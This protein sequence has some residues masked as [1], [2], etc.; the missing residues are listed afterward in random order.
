MI[1]E[2]EKTS[3]EKMRRL[4]QEM[5]HSQ[6]FIE[7]IFEGNHA[8]RF[9]VND[10][11]HP[12]AALA[13]P[14]CGF[15]FPAGRADDAAFNVALRERILEDL[16]P[17]E[18]HLLLFPTSQAWQ[19]TLDALFADFARLHVAHKAFTFYPDTFTARHGD[20]REHIPAG[21]TVRRYNRPLAEAAG[22]EVEFWGGLDRFLTH[23][24]GTAVLKDGEIVS[25][26]HAVM[27]GGGEAEI[28]IETTEPYR[29][30]GFATLAACAF[31]GHCLDQ[32]LRPAWS[33]WDN[34]I[35]S[36]ILAQK[37]GFNNPVDLPAI[38]T[39]VK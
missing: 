2:L 31:I 21:Y 37:L 34:N 26:C 38:Y 24:I 1:Q 39:K 15:L 16:A 11:E 17:P 13:A 8:G 35:P 20:W 9:F 36:Q 32:G 28:S 29:R 30:Q 18:G 14:L 27:V 10:L 25:R 3:Y 22:V 23:G 5:G 6:L 19:N 7:A 4:F 33:C 12:T